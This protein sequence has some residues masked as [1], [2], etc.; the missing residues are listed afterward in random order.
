MFSSSSFCEWTM[1]RF[2]LLY[3]M[4]VW[5]FFS[6]P[7]FEHGCIYLPRVS[8]AIERKKKG[9][10]D[11]LEMKNPLVSTALVEF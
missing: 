3:Y 6:F 10:T 1:T 7:D 11:R 9:K 4:F 2:L 5:Y 8:Q